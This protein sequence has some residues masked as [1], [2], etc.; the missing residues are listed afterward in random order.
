MRLSMLTIYCLVFFVLGSAVR[1]EAAVQPSEELAATLPK[2]TTEYI[3]AEE[4]QALDRK[5]K[6]QVRKQIRKDLRKQLKEIR[7]Q[8]KT[9]DDETIIL[10]VLAVILPPLAIFIHDGDA[11]NRFW[12]T[13]L[14][15]VGGLILGAILNL[16]LLLLI[17]SIAYSL[18]IILSER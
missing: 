13:L 3:T 15:W 16:W 4:Y 17:P 11:S 7:K 9:S 6:R 1:L 18:S 5:E 8:E 12:F 10:A 2:P 14:L